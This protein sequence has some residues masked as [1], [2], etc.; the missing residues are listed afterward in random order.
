MKVRTVDLLEDSPSSVRIYGEKGGLSKRITEK[1]GHRKKPLIALEDKEWFGCQ[2][3]ISLRRKM[4]R[5]F[6]EKDRL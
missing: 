2:S 3:E 4:N 6:I 5:K 1:R